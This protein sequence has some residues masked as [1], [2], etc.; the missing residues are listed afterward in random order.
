MKGYLL[1]EYQKYQLEWMICHDCSID[2]LIWEL[3]QAQKDNPNST[4]EELYNHWEQNRGFEGSMWACQ[5]EWM[6][7][8]WLEEEAQL[9]DE[10]H[11]CDRLLEYM[12][13][14]GEIKNLYEKNGDFRHIVARLYKHDWAKRALDE[15]KARTE[16]AENAMN[17][18][19][20]KWWKN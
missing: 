10:L 13:I 7:N 19:Y 6:Q 17:E 9:S 1:S 12:D 16:S 14:S 15:E 4:I 2:D 8:E 3:T 20:E 18:A 11:E 5:N